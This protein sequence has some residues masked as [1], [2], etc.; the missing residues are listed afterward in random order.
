MY[1]T[2]E[3]LADLQR[4]LDSSYERAGSHLRSIITPER[5]LSAEQLSKTL[6][7]MCLLSL[8]TVTARG[9]PIVAPVDGQFYQGKLW[10]G[11]AQNSVRFRHI[12]ARPQVS[13]NHVRGEELVVI[14]HGTA[15]EIDT[16]TGEYEGFRGYL[17]EVYGPQLD[18]WGH[19]G[20]AASAWI[21]P[22]VMFAASFRP[23][24]SAG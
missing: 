16:S 10:F 12:R 23:P 1:E 9:E 13:A 11:S 20:T 2:A 8:A 4:L 22:R 18:N 3:Q 7:G 21:E 19:W 6:T 15:R 5:R 24:T 17:R 14:V